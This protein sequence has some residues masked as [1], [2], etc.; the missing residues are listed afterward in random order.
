MNNRSCDFSYCGCRTEIRVSFPLRIVP[1]FFHHPYIRS[2][3][4]D[5]RTRAAQTN[6]R[7]FY[8]MF[9]FPQ[10]VPYQGTSGTPQACHATPRR[11]FWWKPCRATRCRSWKSPRKDLNL[12]LCKDRPCRQGPL[13]LVWLSTDGFAGSQMWK[14]GVQSWR[15][16]I[17][18]PASPV[19]WVYLRWEMW[20]IEMNRNK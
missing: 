8:P 17:V 13:T 14:N 19:L 12:G 11:S 9:V 1:L 2:Q 3:Q 18:P 10:A 15:N 20:P 16:L 5:G 6:L 7:L 4:H